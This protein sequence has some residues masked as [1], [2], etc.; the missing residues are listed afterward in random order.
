MQINKVSINSV[1]KIQ[2]DETTSKECKAQKNVENT[3]ANSK[4]YNYESKSLYSKGSV[5]NMASYALLQH[6]ASKDASEINSQNNA[7]ETVEVDKFG[8][9]YKERN[10]DNSKTVIAKDLEGKETIYSNRS[11]ETR[12]S[13]DIFCKFPETG[14]SKEFTM[15]KENLVN[16]VSK[17]HSIYFKDNPDNVKL[18]ITTI[19]LDK[20]YS[21]EYKKDTA[22]ISKDFD[23]KTSKKDNIVK[24]KLSDFLAD[25][26][27][28]GIKKYAQAKSAENEN[29][30]KAE[31]LRNIMHNMPADTL[32]NMKDSPELVN[33]VA[34]N[35]KENDFEFA[36]N[37][38]YSLKTADEKLSLNNDP[39]GY[40][41]FFNAYEK[42]RENFVKAFPEKL[43][44][45]LNGVINKTE[46][47]NA[48]LQKDFT[49][50]LLNRKYEKIDYSEAG[51]LIN[52]IEEDGKNEANTVFA[53]AVAIT[54]SVTNS[55]PPEQFAEDVKIL[56]QYFPNTLLAAASINK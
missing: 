17:E 30:Q 26:N 34:D 41:K 29:P 42:E 51:K 19:G 21:V 32:L 47:G 18:A 49:E 10:S 56:K 55:N 12:L 38:N 11:G 8:N 52:N 39:K 50:P 3:N 28:K 13:T 7:K 35:Y 6:P 33:Q 1:N 45:F 24:L 54:N 53:Y 15:K 27:T 44:T 37:L 9:Y 46:K 36:F 40:H 5:N 2:K 20:T 16:T 22:L 23:P 43:D 14:I 31:Y 25:E 4:I 48:D